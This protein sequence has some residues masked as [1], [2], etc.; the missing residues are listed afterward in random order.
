[1]SLCGPAVVSELISLDSGIVFTLRGQEGSRRR[2]LP[3][4]VMACPMVQQYL[5]WLPEAFPLSS[6]TSCPQSDQFAAVILSPAS[7]SLFEPS[8]KQ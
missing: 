7:R 4:M 1:M 2:R 3:A 5:N 6:D 8:V